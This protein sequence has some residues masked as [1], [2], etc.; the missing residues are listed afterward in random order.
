MRA[1][2]PVLLSEKILY[3]YIYMYMDVDAQKCICFS[4][5]KNENPF[6]KHF[7]LFKYK[8]NRH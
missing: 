2:Y 4:R 1:A 6:P 7:S 8:V 5:K 3:I